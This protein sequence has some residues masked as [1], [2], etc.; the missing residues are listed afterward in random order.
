MFTG[1]MNY[2]R[3]RKIVAANVKR[4]REARDISVPVAAER[5]GVGRQ[6]W[7]LIESGGGNLPLDR[8]D[9]VAEILGVSVTELVAASG[10]GVRKRKEPAGS[11]R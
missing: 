3:T 2:S 9:A 5:L 10:N 4:F 7:Y 6:Y 8:L 11:R 1:D